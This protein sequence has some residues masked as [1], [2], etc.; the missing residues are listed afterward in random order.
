MAFKE[1]AVKYK[2]SIGLILLFVLIENVSFI[3]EPTFFGKL[4][5]SL[6][7]H[8]YDHETVDYILPLI[9]WIIVY[10]INVIGIQYHLKP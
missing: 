3:I 1:I 9:I 7:D 8:F 5:D 2:Y 6:I 4:L 10:M